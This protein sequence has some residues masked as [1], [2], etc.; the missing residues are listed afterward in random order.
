MPC[1]SFRGF[2]PAFRVGAIALTTCF[3]FA[4]ALA[5]PAAAED[6]EFDNL[7][8]M[9]LATGQVVE[10]D[11][12]INWTNP[13]GKTYCF[14][15][16][17][18]KTAFLENPDENL[19]KA[20][21]FFI[22]KDLA[23]NGAEEGAAVGMGEHDAMGHQASPMSA[24]PQT[25]SKEFTEEDVNQ[26]VKQVMDARSEDG[27]FQFHDPRINQDLDLVFEKTRI[28][29]GMAGYGWFANLIFH[30]EAEPKKQY[31]LDFWFKPEGEKLKLMDIRVQK[32]P[33]RDGDGWIMVTRLP[34]AWWWLPVSEHPGETEVI[35]AW[36]V[37]SAVHNYIAD[38]KEK[39]GALMVENEETGQSV[40]L[41]F[42]EIHQPV[43]R[44]KKDGE[45]FICTDFRK[46]GTQN[47]YYDID[48]WVDDKTGELKVNKIKM[49]KVP[50]EEDGIWQQKM[51]YDFK[52]MDFDITN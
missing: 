11:C 42:V 38:H 7:C 6:G 2:A 22:A 19:E 25:L 10:T 28:V 45:Y 1:I 35:R 40:P 14:G 39:G 8:A 44:L 37:M 21:E 46:K 34:V 49:H 24:K 16:E 32:G 52:D 33:K 30:D 13:A 20:K 17:G 26:A 15:S 47:E 5:L 3:L 27:V 48:F 51:L 41:E 36:H 23:A 50:V 4:F 18:S 31:A 12:S 43:R 9:G 29:R